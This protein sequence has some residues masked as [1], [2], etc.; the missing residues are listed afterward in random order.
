MR[1]LD[2][3]ILARALM[4][5]DDVQSPI[6]RQVFREPALVVATVVMELVWVLGSRTPWDAPHIAALILG[7]MSVP[8]LLFADA[9]AVRWSLGKYAD[10][11]DF[12]DMLHLALSAS[13]TSFATFDQGIAR[14]ADDS[15]VPV[16]TLA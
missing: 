7:L 9:D 1:S 15:V 4:R 10:G 12:A 13:A 14:F 11:A 3:N 16:E 5:D 2:T 8:H 6:A